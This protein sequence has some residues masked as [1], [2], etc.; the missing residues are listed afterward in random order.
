MTMLSKFA[1]HKYMYVTNDPP[2][3]H[4]SLLEN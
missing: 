2:S 3:A 1:A 4:T